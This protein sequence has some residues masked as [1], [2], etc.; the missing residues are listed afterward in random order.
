MLE[1]V[2]LKKEYICQEV[3]LMVEFKFITNLAA[4]SDRGLA[5]TVQCREVI[6]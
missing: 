6:G 5:C 4:I 1:A 2:N 3:L